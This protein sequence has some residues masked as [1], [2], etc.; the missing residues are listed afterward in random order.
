MTYSNDWK[1]VSRKVIDQERPIDFITPVK[2]NQHS[3]EYSLEKDYGTVN[4][5][6]DKNS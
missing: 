1:E 4:G 2:S 6:S 3:L 5:L